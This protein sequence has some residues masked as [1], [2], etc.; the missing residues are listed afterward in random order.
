MPGF[1]A[2]IVKTISITNAWYK[3]KVCWY[4]HANKLLH[5]ID[6]MCWY[7]HANNSPILNNVTQTYHNKNIIIPVPNKVTA[8]R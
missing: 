4:P 2:F 5:H 1:H 3:G 6:K 7:P 8:V